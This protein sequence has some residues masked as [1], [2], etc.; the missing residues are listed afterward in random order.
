[1]GRVLE[2]MA[3]LG[4]PM[5][6]THGLRTV[7]EQQELFAQGRTKPGKRVTNCDGIT[8]K[9]RHQL[10][11]DGF[12]HAVDCC[13]KGSNPLGDNQPWGAYGACG[14]ALGLTWGGRFKNLPFDGPHLE[15]P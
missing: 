11:R 2:A 8:K 15:L 12:G 13:F 9:S 5:R 10:A 1:M 14:E 3:A 4:Y 6:V 7:G